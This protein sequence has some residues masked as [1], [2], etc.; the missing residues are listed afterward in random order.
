MAC[1]HY[2]IH[3][4]EKGGGTLGVLW[5]WRERREKYRLEGATEGGVYCQRECSE[6]GSDCE[7]VNNHCPEFG[8][9]K[10]ERATLPKIPEGY[11]LIDVMGGKPLLQ[12]IDKTSDLETLGQDYD[13]HGT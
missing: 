5:G 10:L 2:R 3:V 12:K 7:T 8:Q 1:E 13:Y 6:V 11:G 9:L 4:Y